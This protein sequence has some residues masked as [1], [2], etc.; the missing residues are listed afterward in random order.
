MINN[1]QNQNFGSVKV[2]HRVKS[3]RT[4][5]RNMLNA[6]PE[7]NTNAA[8]HNVFFGI[9]AQGYGY[10]LLNCTSFSKENR[11][12]NFLFKLFPKKVTKHMEKKG[13][14][15]HSEISAKGSYTNQNFGKL[16][17]DSIEDLNK[18][19]EKVTQKR[20]ANSNPSDN[21]KALKK[22]LN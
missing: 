12:V 14:T 16:I 15:G 11:V 8:N 9:K 4:T 6:A 10:P 13:I 2:S 7:I 22:A 1:I 17:N 20:A 3:Y 19:T 18:K 5:V 21:W